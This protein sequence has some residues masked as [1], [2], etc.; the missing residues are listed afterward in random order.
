MSAIFTLDRHRKKFV[1]GGQAL[2]PEHCYS[3]GD[4][5]TVV[6][7]TETWLLQIPGC[8]S[9]ECK[10]LLNLRSSAREIPKV[11]LQLVRILWCCCCHVRDFIKPLEG[12]PGCD[13][14]SL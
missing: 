11:D 1:K 4:R 5:D 8:H 10:L 3:V 13:R 6:V 2:C 14:E 9:F 7:V 12:L